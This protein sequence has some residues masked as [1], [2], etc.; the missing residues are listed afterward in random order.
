[1]RIFEPSL[2]PQSGIGRVIAGVVIAV[3]ATIALLAWSP[4][5]AFDA[6]AAGPESPHFQVATTPA[7]AA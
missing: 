6:G 7:R 2:A 4:A 1:M 3:V 5:S